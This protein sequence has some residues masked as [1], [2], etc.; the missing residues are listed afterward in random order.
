M[1]VIFAIIVIVNAYFFFFWLKQMV[2][3]KSVEILKVKFMR[4]NCGCIL[5]R[6]ARIKRYRKPRH[7]DEY[8]SDSNTAVVSLTAINKVMPI[9]TK[10][11]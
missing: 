2:R 8:N 9:Q 3:Q 1:L 4:R 5:F 11:A 6:L 7:D 10:M